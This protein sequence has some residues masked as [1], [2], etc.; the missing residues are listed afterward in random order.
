MDTAATPILFSVGNIVSVK[1][2]RLYAIPGVIL[3]V[4][5]ENAA[6]G[7]TMNYFVALIMDGEVRFKHWFRNHELTLLDDGTATDS[8]DCGE[9]SRSQE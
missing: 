9:A 3:E 2:G 6:Q 5:H 4:D 1:W 8:P 7:G